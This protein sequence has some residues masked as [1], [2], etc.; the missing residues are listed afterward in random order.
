MKLKISPG[1]FREYISVFWRVKLS[2]DPSLL[3]AISE[4]GDI[5]KVQEKY[6]KGT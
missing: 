1:K 2:F 3:S 4:L 6:G 5:G